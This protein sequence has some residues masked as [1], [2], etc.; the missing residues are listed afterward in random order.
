MDDREERNK[1]IMETQEGWAALGATTFSLLKA[2]RRP[3]YYDVGPG[4]GIIQLQGISAVRVDVGSVGTGAVLIVTYGVNANRTTVQRF[5]YA[6]GAP[7]I[8]PE[9][10]AHRDRDAI[11]RLL[12][13]ATW[14][15]R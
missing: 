15:T 12:G 4:L 7:G 11:G 5:Y 14:E 13:V 2:A 10:A 1:A 8:D 6:N 9:V 3:A